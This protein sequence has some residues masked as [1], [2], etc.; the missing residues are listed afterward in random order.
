[1]T[2]LRKLFISL[3]N[4]TL[5]SQDKAWIYKSF[6]QKRERKNNRRRSLVY[7]SFAYSLSTLSVVAFILFGNFFWV[8]D[9]NQTQLSQSVD[10]QSI[11]EIT[12]VKWT[13]SVYNN[14]NR[15]IDTNVIQLSDRV[16]V[17]QSSTIKVLIHDSFTAEIVWPAQFEIIL[18]EDENNKNY[19]IKFIN[20]WDYI[21][22]NSIWESLDKEISVQTSDGVTIQ[23]NQNTNNEKTSFEIKTIPGK[24]NKTI[25]NKS[26]SPLEITTTQP[27]SAWL[28]EQITS[29]NKTNNVIIIDPEQI[30]E[31]TKENDQADSWIKIISQQNIS[32]VVTPVA[33]TTTPKKPSTNVV[34]AAVAE[35]LFTEKDIKNIKSNLHRSFLQKEYN[36]LV[37]YHFGGNQTAY[38]IT[39]NSI[40]DR[41]NRLA[42]IIKYPKNNDLNLWWIIVFAEKLLTHYE[43][44]KE[45]PQTSYKN[46][47]TL[48]KKLTELNKHNFGIMKLTTKDEELTLEHIYSLIDLQQNN[49]IYRFR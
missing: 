27:T 1:M 44:T 24:D 31:I 9:N 26:S 20:W 3:G 8:F 35:P 48:I 23:R 39:K 13:F 4:Q 34:V 41:L 7:K 19:N 12:S 11:G 37:V 29:T 18:D 32:E 25:I 40:N 14:E 2:T 38:E 36:S 49:S 21:A 5:S 45:I 43:W 22:I 17:D 46:L 30:I 47:P 16:I 28:L 33:S 15:K 42:Q 6:L 10:A